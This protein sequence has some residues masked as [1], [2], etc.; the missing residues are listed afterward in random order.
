M[1]GSRKQHGGLYYMP[2]LT[3]TPACNQAS[4]ASNLWHMRLGHPSPSRL[5]LAYSL[6]PTNNISCENYCTVCP[7]AKQT[8]LPFPL[9][10][11]STK[12]SFD[13]LHCD[14][15]GP[16][17]T[18]T[19]LGARFFL[20]IVDDFT[21]CTWVFLMKHKSETQHILKSFINF[22]HTQFHVHVK[23]VRVD[24]GSE[25]LTM[26]NFF[27]F[28][29][30]KYQ[31]TCV[32]TPQQNGVVER[33]HRHILTVARALMFQSCLHLH[34]WGECVLTAVYLIN[35]L[36]SPLISNKTHFEMLYNRPPSLNHLKVSGCLSYA[37]VVHHIHKF[38]S[39][40]K[41]CVFVG[42][43]TG[44]KGYKLYDLESK[45]FFVS[46]DVKFHETTFPFFSTSTPSNSDLTMQNF[47]SETTETL[48][49]TSPFPSNSQ[50]H[51]P[52]TSA[53]VNLDETII[54]NVPPATTV[55]SE[56]IPP[57][58]DTSNTHLRQP[59]R[60]KQPPVWHR[61]FLM[62]SQAN[63][64]ISTPSSIT[65]TR[66]PLSNFLSYSRF[67]PSH[68]TFLAAITKHIEPQSYAQAV[69]DPNWQQAMDTEL[70]ALQLNN[71]WTLV[72]LPKGHKPIGCKWVYKIKYRADG[73]IERYK[74]RLV[75]KGYDQIEGIDYQETFS[76]T[77][78][79]T[80]LRCLLTVAT[81]RHWCI[82]QLDVQNAFLHGNLHEIVY[83]EPP[84]G[85]I[86]R[87]QGKY[88][89]PAQ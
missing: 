3:R 56:T 74:A 72:P 66:Y 80:T 71:T 30:I 82:H 73:E 4:Q 63:H 44:Q 69:L 21:R 70:E 76:P 53:V 61:D 5:K 22:A 43:L 36:P 62:S 89:M 48:L 83:R 24:N 13:L 27:K 25:F 75:A 2:S 87:R 42:Y 39:R 86:L 28:H 20:T 50:H 79:L 64:F 45:Q 35:R 49:D 54:T 81:A 12:A 47:L 88:R 60:P 38:E 33:K 32:Y 59:T 37:T 41:R 7:M 85:L 31:H 19:H 68:S 10:S 67:S 14:I 18:Q 11:I 40:A 52:D 15:W 51:H 26:K 55:P 9:S 6:L 8:R 16:H 1:I 34:F 58:S 46:R 29:G 17:K 57:L 23:A 65:G 84:H 78:K 77:A